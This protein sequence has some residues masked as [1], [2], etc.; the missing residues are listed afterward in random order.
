MASYELGGCTYEVRRETVKDAM[1]A[2][3]LARTFPPDTLW[4]FARAF[5]RYAILTTVDGQPVLGKP[6]DR[7]SVAELHAAAEAW[8]EDDPEAYYYFQ[9][10]VMK[11]RKEGQPNADHLKPG[12]EPGN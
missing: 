3:A 8:G 9:D 2:D 12:V 1:K 10:A 6:I 4:E 5:S 11:A 7:V